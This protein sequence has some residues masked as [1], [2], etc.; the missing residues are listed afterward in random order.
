MAGGKGG[1]GSVGGS[2][3]SVASLFAALGLKIDKAAWSEGNKL[4]SDMR[5]AALGIGA[6]FGGAALGKALISY[7]A[8]LEDARNQIAGMLALSKKTDVADQFGDADRMVEQLRQ[9]AA[10]LPGTTAEY[11]SMLGMLTQPLISAGLGL[12]DLEDLTVNSVVGA[13]A[14]GIAWDVAARDIDQA[15]RGQ[16]HSIDQ[17]TGKILG[18]IGYVGE[19]GRKR[20]NALDQQQRAQVLKAALSQKQLT[21]L[22]ELQGKSFR[23]VWSTFV[24]SL[25]QFLGK[26]GLPLFKALGEAISAANAYLEE[27]A[28]DLNAIADVIGSVLTAAFAALS[29]IIGFL[30]GGSDEAT[31]VLI[32]IAAA[33]MA[34]VVPAL[35]S[36]AAGWI[37]ALW[38]VLAIGVAVAA[39]VMFI[40][41]AGPTIVGVFKM[42]WNWVAD[43]AQ[44][45]ANKVMDSFRAITGFFV[46]IG[47]AIRNAFLDAMADIGAAVEDVKKAVWDLFKDSRVAK[48]MGLGGVQ[49]M[50][51]DIEQQGYAPAGGDW[52]REN[53]RREKEGQPLLP[54]P[55][56][57]AP[58]VSSSSSSSAV[59]NQVNMP[60]TV[61]AGP[62]MD[63]Q[64]LAALV[65]KEAAAMWS[66]IAQNRG[67]PR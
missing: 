45:A 21:Q 40:K 35:V 29:E 59:T 61:T 3:V 16:F 31:A 25:E 22:A 24:D 2:G 11:V 56:D 46:D 34:V 14:L 4:I 47:K 39:V 63:E 36:M 33:I 19:E 12:Q 13:K 60:I 28:D 54:S 17:F 57:H 41:K 58:G 37:A 15:V 64:K 52:V 55:Y 10:K 18:S 6:Y 20:F 42:A 32:G 9:R 43:K 1:G 65:G 38:P 49:N 26:V 44:W 23:G 53:R 30:L 7:N 66:T 50:Q 48:L 62:G 5:T 67:L 8:N 27:H 51:Q